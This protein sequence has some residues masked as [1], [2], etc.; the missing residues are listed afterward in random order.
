MNPLEGHMC[1]PANGHAQSDG[2]DDEVMPC[3]TLHKH[4]TALDAPCVASSSKVTSGMPPVT[5][6]SAL[7][8]TAL[9]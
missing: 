3:S 6:D 4:C 2:S 5:C 9:P 8:C 1:G 7:S